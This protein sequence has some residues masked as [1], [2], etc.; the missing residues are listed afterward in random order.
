MVFADFATMLSL[1]DGVTLKV[2]E[3][4][5]EKYN[6]VTEGLDDVDHLF[7]NLSHE[8]KVLTL[9]AHGLNEE[10]VAA[11]VRRVIHRQAAIRGGRYRPTFSGIHFFV[12]RLFDKIAVAVRLKAPFGLV[13]H[14]L[15]LKRCS[16]FSTGVN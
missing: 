1:L 5:V 7:A 6:F 15:L 14:L 8:V 11:V 4:L 9:S 12:K 3:A 16:C 10:V 2:F 13:S